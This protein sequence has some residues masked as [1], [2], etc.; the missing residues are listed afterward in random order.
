MMRSLR[1]ALVLCLLA[2]IPAGIT[3]FVHRDLVLAMPTLGQGEATLEMTRQWGERVL[4]LDAR[5]QKKFEK[6][7]VPGALS[8]NED[9]WEESLLP[10]VAARES[11]ASRWFSEPWSSLKHVHEAW[12]RARGIQLTLSRTVY[13]CDLTVPIGTVRRTATWNRTSR[14]C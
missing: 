13:T 6:E 4:W 8:L 9:R 3:G 14:L 7:H 2:T 1:D 12:K 10:V 11:L 5:S